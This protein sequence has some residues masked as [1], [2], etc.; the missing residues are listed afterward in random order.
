MVE[1]SMT[2]PDE[3][4]AMPSMKTIRERSGTEGRRGPALGESTLRGGGFYRY[5]VLGLLRDGTPRHGYALMKDYQQRS[6]TPIGSGRFYNKLQRLAAEGLVTTAANPP[7]AD[8]RRTPY[9]ITST[10]AASFDVW[11]RDSA[12]PDSQR[13]DDLC[14]HALLLTAAEPA[15]VSATLDR[16]RN[17]IAMRGA[18]I[19]EAHARA[20]TTRRASP[21]S[22]FYPLPVVLA[23]RLKHATADIE[24]IDEFRRAYEQ[25]MR[26]RAEARVSRTTPAGRRSGARPIRA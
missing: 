20:L 5:L 11:L 7:G 18:R 12:N 3:G 22:A 14:A 10:G 21:P 16:W 23:R 6:G 26:R 17:D 4:K 8:P 25:W 24:F 13:G 15:V 2:I 19:E 1:A 9:R